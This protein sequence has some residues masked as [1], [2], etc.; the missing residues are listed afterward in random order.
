VRPPP[1]RARPFLME[2]GRPRARRPPTCRRRLWRPAAARGSV[3]REARTRASSAP[4]VAGRRPAGALGDAGRGRARVARRGRRDVAWA[5]CSWVL[6]RSARQRHRTARA[7]SLLAVR[8]WQR[9]VPSALRSR[10]VPRLMRATVGR[11]RV[12]PASPVPSD[13]TFASEPAALASEP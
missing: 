10:C 12:A 8:T 3:A 4:G 2:V 13:R 1:V 6:P 9:R 11:L 5:S 7:L